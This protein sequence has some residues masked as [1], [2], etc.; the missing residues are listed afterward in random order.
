[1]PEE[2]NRVLTDRLSDVLFLPS[3]DARQNLL[4]EGIPEERI[5]FAGNVMV[6]TLI[7]QLPNA[8]AHRRA[9]CTWPWRADAMR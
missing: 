2:V 9:G 8:R 1:M 3:H 7:Q 6:D 4:G 5:V